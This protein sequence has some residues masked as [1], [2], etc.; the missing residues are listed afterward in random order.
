VEK[1][2]RAAGVPTECVLYEVARHEILNDF[3]YSSTVR[4]ILS[5]IK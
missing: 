4:D 1:K 2:L 5:F 3:T